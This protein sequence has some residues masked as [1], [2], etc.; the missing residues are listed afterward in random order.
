MT[1]IHLNF[2]DD[3]G[4][5]T[6]TLAVER[7]GAD[8]VLIGGDIAEAASLTSILTFLSSRLDRPIYFVLG[9]HDYY[10]GA[11]DEVQAHVR[12]LSA[13]DRWLR[14]LPA[15]GVVELSSNAALI[16]HGGWG[17][18]R[19]GN[20]ST[21]PVQLN[22]FL[23][24]RD[25]VGTKEH[26]DEQIARF[27]D[28]AAHHVRDVLTRAAALYRHV[29]L[30]T[31]VPPYRE[32]CWHEGTISDDDWLPFFTCKAVGDA[33]NDVMAG[34]PMCQLTVLC[35]HTHSGGIARIAPNIL[36]KTGAATYG[37]P[38]IQEVLDLA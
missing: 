16:G 6:F 11:I 17:D 7:S 27:G 35:G 13:S 19:L 12:A 22:D 28:L 31:H 9:N 10:H 2:L 5:C 15:V 3:A 25:L 26:G 24:I 36:V 33:I 29:V 21:T 1:D 18:G 8:A 4:L 14:W 20:L 30:L 37:E 34:H 38:E 23:L 32:A